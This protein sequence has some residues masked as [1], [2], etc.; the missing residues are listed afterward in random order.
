MPPGSSIGTISAADDASV[1]K[2]SHHCW[3]RTAGEMGHARAR[4]LSGHKNGIAHRR[5]PYDDAC[6]ECARRCLASCCDAAAAIE[7]GASP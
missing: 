6:A 3:P 5:H 2:A 1:P 4:T 7:S